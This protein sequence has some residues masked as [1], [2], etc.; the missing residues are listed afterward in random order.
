VPAANDLPKRFTIPVEFAMPLVSHVK[1]GPKFMTTEST[2]D[3]IDD[4][5]GYYKTFPEWI[6][7][8]TSIPENFE[9]SFTAVVEKSGLLSNIKVLSTSDEEMARKVVAI[10]ETSPKWT[11]ARDNGKLARALVVFS[12]SSETIETKT[13]EDSSVE[14]QMPAFKGG[15]LNKFRNWVTSKL[16]YPEYAYRQKI[17]GNVL[18]K[19]I[20]ERDGNL[21]EIEVVHS[22]NDMLAR[23]AVRVVRKSPKWT[24]GKQGDSNVRVAFL[25]PMAFRLPD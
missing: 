3:D 6:K 1:D 10:I 22:P 17:Q 20:I 12:F 7:S 25:L 15:D 14:T 23:E 5:P 21:T 4:L 2:G 19:F 11:P 8:K 16:V 18:L 9:I 13:D 24:P